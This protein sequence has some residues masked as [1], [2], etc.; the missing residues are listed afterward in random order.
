MCLFYHKKRSSIL[1]N[2]ET[3]NLQLIN[4]LTLVVFLSVPIC[5][6]YDQE[7]ACNHWP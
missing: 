2:R 6:K 1:D 5:I 4:K 7:K 3:T